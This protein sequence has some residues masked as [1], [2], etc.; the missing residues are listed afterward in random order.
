[1][2]K[3]EFNKKLESIGVN[4]YIF[5]Q[6]LIEL[7]NF[8]NYCQNNNIP[9]IIN[10]HKRNHLYNNSII[11]NL[12]IDRDIKITNIL[13][14]N[15]KNNYYIASIKNNDYNLYDTTI[16]I[17][18]NYAETHKRKI[19]IGKRVKNANIVLKYIEYKYI[20]NIYY[21]Y[22]TNSIYHGQNRLIMYIPLLEINR[23]RNKKYYYKRNIYKMIISNIYKKNRRYKNAKYNYETARYK[24]IA[25]LSIYKQNNIYIIDI[26]TIFRLDKDRTNKYPI[27]I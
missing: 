22:D 8:K 16:K 7:L 13:I 3:D 20:R 15:N 19:K 18:D 21:E 12:V 26:I 17:A 27:V 1:M 4:K 24:Y 10:F 25:P 6:Y 23:F 11:T 5:H 9:Y 14:K 2:N